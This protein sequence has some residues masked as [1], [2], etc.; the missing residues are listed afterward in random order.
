MRIIKPES[1]MMEEREQL[2]QEAYKSLLIELKGEPIEEFVLWLQK[3]G[4]KP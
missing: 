3:N 2:F 4:G 1:D